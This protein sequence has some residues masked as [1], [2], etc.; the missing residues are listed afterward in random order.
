MKPVEHL[1]LI[2][3]TLV[4]RL[5]A[6]PVFF[7]L[8]VLWAHGQY[9]GPYRE[10]E[11]GLL[12]LYHL[13]KGLS[14]DAM[15]PHIPK[16]SFHALH[17]Q[18][19]KMHFKS[20][21]KQVNQMLAT[22]FSTFPIR[23]LSAKANNPP[24]FKH[25]TLHLDGHDTRLSSKEKSSAEMYSYKLKKS[26]VRTQVCMDPNGM[27][28]IVS[29]SLPCKDNNDGTMLVGM[30]VH[31]H[32]HELDCIAIDGGYTQYIKK[33]VEDTSMTK[34]N[35]CFP[36]RKSRGKDLAQDEANYNNIFG[37]FRS[38]ME[39]EFG[40]LG[41]TF[42]LH[43]NRKPVLVT[44]VE[45]YNLQL[46]LCLLLMNV[47]RMVALL[48]LKE[49]PMHKAWMRDGFDYPT[50]NNTMEQLMEYPP[51]AEILEDA[52]SMAKLQDEFLKMNMEVEEEEVAEESSQRKRQV[53]VA[54][55]VPAS[56]R[57]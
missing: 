24:L 56:K 51:V 2:K 48:G 52:D 37:S 25:V 39:D 40:V 8:V 27:A 15:S 41:A 23:L 50:T 6:I 12:L 53:L 30:K 34:K 16:S 13:V 35:F 7:F 28:L 36:I 4:K 21:L 26:G 32:I 17:S 5:G 38:Q 29:K 31:R 10:V 1:V 47:K 22:M 43:N 46:C 33:L 11:K 55:E 45:T 57:R 19:Y 20:H 42:E 18:F 44:K 49:E 54:V 3:E 14:M 9:P